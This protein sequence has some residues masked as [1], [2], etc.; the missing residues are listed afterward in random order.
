MAPLD[1][2]VRLAAAA[3]LLSGLRK[4][5]EPAPTCKALKLAGL[6]SHRPWAWGL[7][8]IEIVVGVVTLRAVTPLNAAATAVL[9]VF[10][11]A[12]LLRARR[13]GIACGCFGQGESPPS[14]IHL[15]LNVAA[16]AVCAVAAFGG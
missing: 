3:L 13:V 2:A 16:V 10:L 6:P 5:T 4:F 7:A 9:Y 14:P 8:S 11:T 1:F 12:F 15:W